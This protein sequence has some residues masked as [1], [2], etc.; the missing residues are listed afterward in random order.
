MPELASTRSSMDDPTRRGGGA[1]GVRWN[2]AS[3]DSAQIIRAVAVCDCAPFADDHA[4]AAEAA[5]VA[6]VIDQWVAS[7]TEWL[8]V[9]AHIDVRPVRPRHVFASRFVARSR[10]EVRGAEEAEVFETER[11]IEVVGGPDPIASHD[12]WLKAVTNT[13]SGVPIP[14]AHQHLRDARAAT[15]RGDLRKAVIDAATACEVALSTDLRAT[16]T[17]HGLASDVTDKLLNRRGADRLH[18]LFV[19]VERAAGGHRKYLIKRVIEPRNAAA[20]AGHLPT[21]TETQI[22]LEGRQRPGRWPVA[23]VTTMSFGQLRDSL[24]VRKR[25]HWDCSVIVDSTTTQSS[26][27]CGDRSMVIQKASIES[28]SRAT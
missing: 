27:P 24:K 17:S 5:A 14:Q 8:E 20:H 16:L 7:L 22:A 2:G 13:N 26:P 6:E 25:S 10:A 12:D 11:P 1:T 15:L 4:R 3:L 23:R 21:T 19:A 9:L 28:P 18:E